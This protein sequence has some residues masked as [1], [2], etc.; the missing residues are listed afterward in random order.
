MFSCHF[1]THFL[2]AQTTTMAETVEKAEKVI[3]YIENNPIIAALFKFEGLK[4]IWAEV[5]FPGLLVGF[6]WLFRKKFGADGAMGFALM[7]CMVFL[8]N[9]VNDAAYLAAYGVQNG[10]FG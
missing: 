4:Y 3:D 10:W 6:Y 5:L 1:M 7:A 2:I 8:M 9:F